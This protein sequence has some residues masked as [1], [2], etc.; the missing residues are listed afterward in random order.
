MNVTADKLAIEFLG[1]HNTAEEGGSVN[2]SARFNAMRA[3]LIIM[4]A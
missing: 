2:N 3:S 4:G 1:K